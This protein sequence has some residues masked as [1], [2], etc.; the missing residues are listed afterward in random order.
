[1][2]IELLAAGSK[3]LAWIKQGVAE[4]QKRLPRTCALKIQEIAIV[5]RAKNVPLDKL[6]EEEEEK[7]FADILCREQG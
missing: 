2:N 7:E 1:M 3:P 6:K 4:C 5:K